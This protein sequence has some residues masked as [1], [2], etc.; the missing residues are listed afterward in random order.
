LLDLDSF[1]IVK[2]LIFKAILG[3]SRESGL[4]PRCCALPRL[5]KIG[6]Q[7]T[8]GGYGDIW[9]GLVGGQCVCVKIMRIFEDSD[10][11]AVLKVCFSK[12]F[13]C[14]DIYLLGIRSRSSH[15]A[16]AVSP[17]R[18]SLLRFVLSRQKAVSCRPVDGKRAHHDISKA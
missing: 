5:R 13:T 14:F 10:V 4:H 8:G 7:V 2:P 3:L 9:R 6:Q 1:S 17:K 16:P 15:L 11:Q 18:P 12:S